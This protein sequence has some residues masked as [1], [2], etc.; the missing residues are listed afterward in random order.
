MS[1]AIGCVACKS[2]VPSSMW[3]WCLDCAFRRC[4]RLMRGESLDDEPMP[5]VFRRNEHV[6]FKGKPARVMQKS[7]RRIYTIMFRNGKRAQA[8]GCELAEAP[9]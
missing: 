2:S 1:G 5:R 8:T 3:R 4:T 6:L 7:R 9:S